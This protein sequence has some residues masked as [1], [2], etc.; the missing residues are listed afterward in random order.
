M[1]YL[2]LIPV[3]ILI[4]LSLGSRAVQFA[5][6]ST[7]F[8]ADEISKVVQAENSD[9]YR[10][11]SPQELENLLANKDIFLVNVHVPYEGNIPGTDASIH[12][13][14]IKQRLMELPKA[15]DAQI[16]VY[17]R[18]GRMSAIAAEEL[19]LAGYSNIL[20]LEGGFNDWIEAGYQFVR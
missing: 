4:S 19:A 10:N 12:F 1:K 7:P 8:D 11:I 20:N 16:V 15:K 2:L 9:Q 18:N 5:V 6:A 3:L 14:K 13:D 17:C